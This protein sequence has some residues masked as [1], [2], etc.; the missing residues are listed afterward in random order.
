MDKPAIILLQETK[1]AAQKLKQVG[2][3]IW[4]GIHVYAV[5]AQG[6]FGG[7]TLIW[8]PRNPP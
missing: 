5:G 6:A 7:L 4:K 2:S 1:R 8:N 3:Q